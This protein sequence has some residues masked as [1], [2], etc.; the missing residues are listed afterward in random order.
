MNPD[1]TELKQPNPSYFQ[2]ESTMSLLGQSD[3][4]DFSRDDATE[5]K[6]LSSEAFAE[7]ESVVSVVVQPVPFSEPKT[8]AYRSWWGVL[9]LGCLFGFAV[10]SG[11]LFREEIRFYSKNIEIEYLNHQNRK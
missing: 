3:E 7:E 6:G 1:R 11:F 2:G 8:Q 9:L 10:V 5:V 4:T